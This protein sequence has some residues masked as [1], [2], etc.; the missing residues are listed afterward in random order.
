MR[1]LRYSA[2]ASSLPQEVHGFRW[3]LESSEWMPH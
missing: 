1:M 2:V 3:E